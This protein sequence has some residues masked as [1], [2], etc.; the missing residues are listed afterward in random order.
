M[1]QLLSVG[2]ERNQYKWM[3]GIIAHNINSFT[4]K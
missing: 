4:I 3:E 1:F 2:V